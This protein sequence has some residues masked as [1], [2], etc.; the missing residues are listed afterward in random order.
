MSNWEHVSSRLGNVEDAT[1]SV[2]KEVYDAAQD[3]GHD[4]WFMWGMGASG[5]HGTGRAL[6]LMVRNK[7]AG[8][9]IR[10]YIWQNRA[11][12]RLRH[13]IWWQ[14]ITSTVVQPGVVRL[15]ADRENVTAN[16]KDHPHVFLN[17]GAYQAPPSSQTRTTT[18]P[19][20]AALVRE[21]QSA[22]KVGVDGKWGPITDERVLRLRGASWNHRGWPNPQPRRFNIRDVQTVIET[23]V[24]GIWGPK[25]QAALVEWIKSFQST[26]GV[27]S[28]GWW[29]PKTDARTLTLR[30]RHRNNW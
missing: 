9:W 8:D 25:S 29:G 14:R 7:A 23:D 27:K 3:A 6:D 17:P 19:S 21:I 20:G 28:D 15:M 24:D 26:I 12:L 13:V 4:I 10:N 11:R 22:V 1:R 18:A 2:A 5:E 16:H 30:R